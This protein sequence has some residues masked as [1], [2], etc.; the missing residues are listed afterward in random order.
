MI[1]ITCA[2]CNQAIE[3]DSRYS[4]YACSSCGKSRTVYGAQC[5]RRRSEN[6]ALGKTYYAFADDEI[7]SIL[8]SRIRFSSKRRGIFV[9]P[10]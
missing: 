2:S 6:R 9:Q 1:K 4:G 5:A 8:A 3:I 10:D 7:R